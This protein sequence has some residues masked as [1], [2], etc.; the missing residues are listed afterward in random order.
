M[1]NTVL[2]I[3][4]VIIFFVVFNNF[5]NRGILQVNATEA[6]QIQNNKDAL[7]LDVR[8]SQEYAGGHLKSAKLIP[9]G[10]LTNRLNEISSYKDKTVLVYCHSG[11]RSTMA[12]QVLK[13]NGFTKVNNLRGGITA[14]SSSGNKIVK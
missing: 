2:I 1:L 3:V 10:E 6:L 13:K 14:W 12:S 5:N 7:V 9:V 11:N 4:A 8:S